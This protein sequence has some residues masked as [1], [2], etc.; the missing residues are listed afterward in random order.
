MNNSHEVHQL[1]TFS[2]GF[3]N[4][5]YI[6]MDKAS[7]SA[8]VIDPSWE[9]KKLVHKF[10][11]LDIKIDAILLTHSHYDHIN[12]VDPLIKSFNPQVY[13]SRE[14]IKFSGFKCRNLNQL[15][16]LDEI[17]IGETKIMCL[18][19][20]GHSPGSMCYLTQDSLFTG[21][22]VFIEGCGACNFIGGSAEAMFDSIQRIKAILQPDMRI[23]P[24]HSYGHS[25]GQTGDFLLRNNIY[26]QFSRKESFVQFRMRR[27][28][29][30]LFNFK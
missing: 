29:R 25:P 28:Q 8:V 14:E 1:K 9:Y 22:T 5:S 24:G 20:P 18:L 19:T 16:D 7:K 26:F 23:Y 12:Q 10:S 27:N 4:Y 21:D 13:M 2:L 6:I 11:Q 17:W 3:S 30:G 15:N